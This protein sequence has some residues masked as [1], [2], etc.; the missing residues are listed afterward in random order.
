M[1]RPQ[2]SNRKSNRKK[3]STGRFTPMIL[4]SLLAMG[5]ILWGVL[6]QVSDTKKSTMVE[7]SI[8]D[9]PGPGK[10][11]SI[12][13]KNIEQPPDINFADLDR[14]NRL[15]RLMDQRKKKL[16]VEESLDMII[17]SDESF[18]V[19]RTTVRMGDILKKSLLKK[20][21]IFEQ[22]IEPSGAI[23]P[24][25]S[26]EYGIHVVQRGDNLWNI[27]FGIIQ[28]YYK[29]RGVTISTTA[30]QPDGE[31]YSSGVGKLLKFSETVVIVYNILEQ[32]VVKDIDLLD[33][34]SKIVVYN[35][36]EVFSL[37]EEIDYHNV[38]KIQFDGE[39][40]WIPTQPARPER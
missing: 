37:L 18:K 26:D 6:S 15:T 14:Q 21:R 36:N 34:L 27:H 16:G 12:V 25:V 39:T 31:G 28:D 5:L 1:L 35:M 24:K 17:K 38:D 10:N 3:S 22:R 2:K 20:D 4:V 40:I 8:L 30:D 19:G 13:T 33:P 7:L 32:N 29:T 9:S 23:V 11:T